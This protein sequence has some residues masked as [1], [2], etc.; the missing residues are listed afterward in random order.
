MRTFLAAIA[1]AIMIGC[2]IGLS[3]T[4][5]AVPSVRSKSVSKDLCDEYSDN[6]EKAAQAVEICTDDI[7][8]GVYNGWDSKGQNRLATRYNNR[9]IAYG[10]KGDYDRAIADH[11]KAIELDP[12]YA[13]A[14]NNRGVDY[15]D[16][17]Y[18]KALA[19]YNKAVELDPKYAMAYLNRGNIFRKKKGDFDRAI[20]E[21][22]KA[23][24]V[25]TKFALAYYVRG[26]AYSQKKD[27][28][29]AIADYNRAIEIDPRI[30]GAYYNMACLYSV[31]NHIAEACTWLNKAIVAG[32]T[33][34]EH[35]KKDNDLDNV[36][37]DACY[38][39]IISGK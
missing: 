39:T 34:W 9:G 29:K 6:K 28:D 2:N 1:I 22:N 30:I 4:A 10:N 31:N 13:K 19:D 18:E 17:D 21:Y 36:R 14:Y 12:R 7:N 38:K 24:E 20:A 35:I 37:N 33:N 23:L 5:L 8:S 27:T 26:N 11:N 3:N 32:Y 16:K 25:D 15:A